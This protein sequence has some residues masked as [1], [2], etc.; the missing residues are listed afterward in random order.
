MKKRMM[1]KISIIFLK[2]KKKKYLFL[3]KFLKKNGKFFFFIALKSNNKIYLLL[4]FGIFFMSLRTN[5][6]LFVNFVN[7]CHSLSNI[8]GSLC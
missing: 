5:Y 8:G 6:N 3:L 4:I 2:K 7:R 1:I